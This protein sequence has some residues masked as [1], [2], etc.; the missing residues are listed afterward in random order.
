M[1]PSSRPNDDHIVSLPD[2][3][4]NTRREVYGPYFSTETQSMRTVEFPSDNYNGESSRSSVSLQ[5]KDLALPQDEDFDTKS[6]ST[7]STIFEGSHAALPSLCS[8]IYFE[9]VPIPPPTSGKN[10][11]FRVGRAILQGFV[12]LFCGGRRH[13]RR[14]D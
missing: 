11:P 12:S 1:L 14:K 4:R 10:D 2:Y 3:Y 13:W 5:T 7:E 9:D 6:Q 8:S